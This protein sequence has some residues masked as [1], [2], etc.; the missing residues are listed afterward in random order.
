MIRCV[1]AARS[2]WSRGSHISW[3]P[4]RSC[5]NG[6]LNGDDYFAIDSHI[7]LSGASGYSAGDFN[8][9]ARVNGDDYFIIDSNINI[10]T[11]GVFPSAAALVQQGA[12]AV[13]EP[14][15][16]GALASLMLFTQWRRRR[17]TREEK[18]GEGTRTLNS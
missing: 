8:Y 16:F 6:T 12:V 14:A 10:Q 5:L 9:D 3:K 17:V 2:S 11:L 13:P 1:S 7:N 15:T 18:A 4:R